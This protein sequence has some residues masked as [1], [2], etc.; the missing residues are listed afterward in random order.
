MTGKFDEISRAE[1]RDRI[2]D[3]LAGRSTIAFIPHTADPG[4]AAQV[5]WEFARYASERY[6]SVTLIDLAL[7]NPALNAGSHAPIDEG[8][9]DVFLY[10]ASLPHVTVEEPETGLHYIGAGTFAADPGEIL[11]NPR[12]PQIIEAISRPRSVI[13]FFVPASGIAQLN[14]KLDGMMIASPSG[15]NPEAGTALAEIKQ[16]VTQGVPLLAAVTGLVSEATA[17]SVESPEPFAQRAGRKVTLVYGA[18]AAI[19]IASIAYSIFSAGP[20]RETSPDETETSAEVV[21]QFQEL[22]SELLTSPD[23]GPTVTTGGSLLAEV[24]VEPAPPTTFDDSDSLFWGVQAA[25]LRSVEG[26]IEY[27]ERLGDDGYLAAVTPVQL[28]SGELWYLVIIGALP[29]SEAASSMRAAL[30]KT[31]HL[32]EPEGRPVRTPLTLELQNES[33]QDPQ[34][35]ISA[36]RERGISAYLLPAADGTRQILIGAFRSE[37]QALV[38]EA[39]LTASGFTTTL[40]SRMGNSQ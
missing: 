2:P 39:M 31:R 24:P 40:I 28:G 15:Y 29:D 33:G 1:L 37:S 14:V 23:S 18:V 11:S 25:S 21:S 38:A 12:W 34:Q 19:A 26:A 22:P 8:I 7:E 30:W 9:V 32:R 4:W 5:T 35:Q 16:A 13:I 6:R 20:D 27:V 10:G 3:L 36:L 17:T